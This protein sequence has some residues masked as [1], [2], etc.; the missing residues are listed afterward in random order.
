[1]KRIGYIL[2]VLLVS[3]LLVGSMLVAAL[4]SDRVETA[5]VRLAAEE[6]SRALGTQATVG[7]VEYRFPARLAIK[8]VFIEDQQHDTL[9]YVGELYAH[10][11]P[12]A[13]FRNEISFSHVRLRDVVANIYRHPDGR[14]NYAFLVPPQKDKDKDRNPLK[15]IVSVRDIR[16][17]NIRVRYEQTTAHLSHAEMDL[18]H[19]SA[20]ALDAQICDLAM[21]MTRK[22]S[23]ERFVVESVKAHMILNDTL[24]SM[25][26]L[27]AS[28]P[29]SCL[30]MSGVEVRFPDADT[31]HLSS[32]AHEIT[33]GLVFH[34]ARLV[35]SDIALFLPAMTR[36]TRPVTLNGSLGGTLDSLALKD[37]AVRYDGHTVLQGDV[38]AIGLPDINNPY[39]RANLTEFRTNAA[40]MQDF[41]SRLE[42]RPVRLPEAVHRLGTIHYRGLAEGYLQDLT[43]HGAFR[44]SLGT[45]TTDGSFKADSVFG[46]MAYN[47][48]VVG[49]R[50]RL[51]RMI[52][53]EDLTSVTLE[54]QS[55][56]RIEKG[57]TRGDIR[58]HVRQLEYKKY[59]YNDLHI[60]GKFD[61]KRYEGR[62][63]DFGI[64]G[65]FNRVQD[66]SSCK[67]YSLC[68][69]NGQIDVCTVCGYQSV[70]NLDNV[71]VCHIVGFEFVDVDFG[72]TCFSCTDVG[73]DYH[74]QFNFT[75]FHSYQTNDG[76]GCSGNQSS[77]PYS[78]GEYEQKYEKQNCKY[79]D[80]GYDS[81]A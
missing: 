19:L 64:D 48:R 53:K 10:F 7:A 75:E 70:D 42:G 17:E 67:V 3:V 57:K 79:Y 4:S 47:A 55:N 27:R 74:F 45:I 32:S 23:R 2:A 81:A 59:V 22:R 58:A 13:L 60:R 68:R 8:E 43:L 20:E 65:N 14:W 40:Y 35:P 69:L 26:T 78:D 31:M 36:L 28:L 77:E 9:A 49:R 56:G 37:I 33:F 30:D 15:S 12:I 25:P 1:M 61:P 5:A 52:G 63:Y 16:F 72:Q 18:K 76:N 71:A 11:R 24:L 34:Q 44:T 41:L 51:G 21:T 66:V 54:L 6:F 46:H 80:K 50:F 38:A 29:N 39:L 62:F 73:F